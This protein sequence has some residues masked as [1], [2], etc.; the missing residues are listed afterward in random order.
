VLNSSPAAQSVTRTPEQG[1]SFHWAF[2]V[3]E[4]PTLLL[5]QRADST[6]HG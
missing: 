5:E 6:G 4:L 2:G 1:L 3:E